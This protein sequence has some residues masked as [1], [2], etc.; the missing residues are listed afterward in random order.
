MLTVCVFVG[1]GDEEFV[2][3]GFHVVQW[4]LRTAQF[5]LSFLVLLRQLFLHLLTE[6]LHFGVIRT[7]FLLFHLSHNSDF[8]AL[9]HS[10][11]QDHVSD[12]FL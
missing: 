8:V 1:V 12:R 7:R 2:A 11:L 4:D 10:V 5:F 9:F 3:V 6:F